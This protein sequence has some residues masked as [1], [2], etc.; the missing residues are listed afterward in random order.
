MAFNISPNGIIILSR[1]DTFTAP[2]S[3][4][5]GT[6]VEPLLYK[7]EAHYT[8]DQGQERDPS[9][10]TPEEKEAWYDGDV[11]YF[12]LMEPNQR[13]EDALVK[14]TY[15]ADDMDPIARTVDLEFDAEDTEYLLPGNYYYQVKLYR[16]PSSSWSGNKKHIETIISKTKFVIME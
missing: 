1:G 2:I 8:D 7:M 6:P 12:G 11:L 14:K 3:V 16:A 9:E 10:L 13:F 5:M 15:K 4:D